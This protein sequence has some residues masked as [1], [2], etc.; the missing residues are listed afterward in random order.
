MES[1]I[2]LFYYEL[3]L[4]K[5][6]IGLNHDSEK[7]FISPLNFK[8]GRV[9]IH[10][11]TDLLQIDLHECFY[12]SVN[13]SF[14]KHNFSSRDLSWQIFPTFTQDFQSWET[15]QNNFF[16]DFLHWA[17]FRCMTFT[18]TY[19]TRCQTPHLFLRTV[20][21]FC[22]VIWIITNSTFG[23]FN[24][25]QFSLLFFFLSSYNSWDI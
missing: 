14:W 25:F 2:V 16:C 9:T 13:L 3:N 10:I 15:H 11:N 17:I 23:G 12:S 8:T 22:I 19:V 18:V 24:R 4:E 21:R 20:T 7:N 1:D 6:K 5:I